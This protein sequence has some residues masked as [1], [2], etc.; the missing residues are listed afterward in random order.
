[1]SLVVARWEG[2]LDQAQLKAALRGRPLAETVTAQPPIAH[3]P[4]KI[5]HRNLS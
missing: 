1:A 4:R 5:T 3:P 2:E